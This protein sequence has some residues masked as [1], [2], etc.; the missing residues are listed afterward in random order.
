MGFFRVMG[1]GISQDEQRIVTVERKRVTIVLKRLP[2]WMVTRG[3]K[4]ERG[5][6][7]KQN[8]VLQESNSG[9]AIYWHSKELIPITYHL[10]MERK[11]ERV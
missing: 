2:S 4:S 5:W 10:L 1:F 6:N 3:S 9:L 8:I 11:R 7:S